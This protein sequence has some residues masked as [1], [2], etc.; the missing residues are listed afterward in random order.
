MVSP[1]QGSEMDKR[2][3]LYGIPINNSTEVSA[4]GSS[5]AQSM[6]SSRLMKAES[7][8]NFSKPLPE[9]RFDNALPMRS[10]PIPGMMKDMGNAVFGMQMP[11]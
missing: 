7:E 11:N 8:L 4:Y 10:P 5:M 9:K 2:P 6:H 3:N 1:M